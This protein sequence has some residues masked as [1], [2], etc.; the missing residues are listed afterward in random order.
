MAIK[1]DASSEVQ[2]ILTLIARSIVDE[3]AKVRVD[4]E[5]FDNETVMRLQVAPNDLW[6]ITGPGGDI[7]L[8]LRSLVAD[9]SV[10][11][12]QLFALDIRATGAE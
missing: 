7:R 5:T 1:I 10:K 9:M 6:A 2:R 12:K 4:A 8:S 11:Y 3:P